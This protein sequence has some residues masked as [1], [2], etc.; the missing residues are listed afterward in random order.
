MSSGDL[1]PYGKCAVSPKYTIDSLGKSLRNAF[2]TVSPPMPE[3]NIPIGRVSIKKGAHLVP[4]FNVFE[5]GN[6]FMPSSVFTRGIMSSP[7]LYKVTPVL[8]SK[9]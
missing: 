5:V 7:P 3:S 9:I 6:Y 2:A 4:L 8:A 1:S